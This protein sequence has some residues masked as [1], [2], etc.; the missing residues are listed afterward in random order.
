MTRPKDKGTQAE[1]LVAAYLRE[2]GWPYAERRALTGVLDK[3]DITGCPGIAW[4][5]KYA[6]GGIRMGTWIGETVTERANAGADHGVLVIKPAGR[7][8]AKIGSW[9]AVMISWDFD[10]LITKNSKFVLMYS[11]VQA[12]AGTTVL[13]DLSQF[14][15]SVPEAVIPVVDRRPP[16]TKE[17]PGEWY[18]ILSLEHMCLLLRAAGYGS[19]ID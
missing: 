2:H 15:S 10:N 8:A 13:R 6:N 7:G 18:R 1:S 11:P 19:P 16:G 12:W 3:G 5:V 4:E 17:A 9:L 14:S